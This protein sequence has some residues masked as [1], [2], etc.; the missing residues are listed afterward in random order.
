LKVASTCSYTL[1]ET[2]AEYAVNFSALIKLM[3]EES[4]DL[5]KRRIKQKRGN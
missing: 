4:A 2:A 3:A 1:A 5:A